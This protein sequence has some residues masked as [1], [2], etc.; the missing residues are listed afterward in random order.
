MAK[1]DS[2]IIGLVAKTIIEICHSL[3]KLIHGNDH[4]YTIDIIFKRNNICVK[5]LEH[6]ESLN[7]YPRL[8][9]QEGQVLYYKMPIGM[10]FKQVEKIHDIFETFLLGQVIVM[11]LKD[12]PDAHFSVKITEKTA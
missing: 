8:I 9:K 11:E 7:E 10:S 4:K 12:H 2:D 6:K 3:S 1:G 5:K